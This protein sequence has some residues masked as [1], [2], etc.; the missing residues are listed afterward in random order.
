MFRSEVFLGFHD[1]VL[2]NQYLVLSS[3]TRRC[4][5][6]MFPIRKDRVNMC[7]G[8]GGG[9]VEITL[10]TYPAGCHHLLAAL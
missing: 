6:P 8:G 9:G 3:A 4:M 10:N 2:K 5:M 7:G 1:S